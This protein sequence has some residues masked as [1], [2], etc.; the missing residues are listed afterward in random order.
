MVPCPE[1]VQGHRPVKP[2]NKVLIRPPASQPSRHDLPQDMEPKVPCPGVVHR[3][4]SHTRDISVNKIM[5]GLRSWWGSPQ[6]LRNCWAV[7]SMKIRASQGRL[8][9][10]GPDGPTALPPPPSDKALVQGF[11]L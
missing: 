3:N 1:V 7:F 11:I 10:A 4:I 9:S 2:L 5:S 6:L 8:A